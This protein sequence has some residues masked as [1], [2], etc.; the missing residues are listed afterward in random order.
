[1]EK[2]TT[3]VRIS[4]EH[5][6]L[7][8]DLAGR[9][10]D[11][12][13]NRRGHYKNNRNS[14]LRGKLGEIA[15]TQ[16][17]ADLGLSSEALWADLSRLSEAD[18]DVTGAFRADVKTWSSQYWAEMGRCVAANQLPKLLAKAD[19]IIWCV[20]DR[21]L[22]SGMTVEVRGWNS[23]S[24]VASAPRRLTGPATGRKVDNY[25][26]DESAVRDIATLLS[27]QRP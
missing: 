12:F 6:T 4:E 13:Q 17:M 26:L 1:M 5:F 3:V 21:Q 10:L 7:A 2:I 8:S 24:D 14:H 22:C 27:F 23:M 11:L 15:A 9:T 18:I 16:V 19:I 20:S 25:Q